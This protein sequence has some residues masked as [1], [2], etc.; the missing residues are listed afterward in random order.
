MNGNDSICLS[1]FIFPEF[2]RQFFEY[3]AHFF[4]GFGVFGLGVGVVDEHKI[5]PGK[6]LGDEPVELGLV[7][8]VGFA[9]YAF[10]E[11]AVNR[12]AELFARYGNAHLKR[13]GLLFGA[14]FVFEY[15][16]TVADETSVGKQAVYGLYAFEFLVFA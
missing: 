14:Y 16:G 5:G 9:Q 3:P 15:D 11:V 10:H 6:L 12:F 1:S 2:G 4:Q 13:H 8:A 7:H